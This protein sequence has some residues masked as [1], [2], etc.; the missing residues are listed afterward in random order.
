MRR[1]QPLPTPPRAEPARG[2]VVAAQTT[3]RSKR[4]P[5]P[6]DQD[7]LATD[8]D[9]Q[10]IDAWAETGQTPEPPA[11]VV[12]PETPSAEPPEDDAAQAQTRVGLL[13]VWK[14]SRASRK[15]LRREVRRFTGRARR[16]R[17]VWIVSISSVLLLIAGS[18]AVAYS[19]LFAVQKIT[20][21]GAAS[22]DAD[23][24]V[25][26]LDGQRGVPLAAVDESAIKSA[27]VTFPLIE[28]YAIEAHPPHEL[29]IRIVERQPIGVVRSDAGYTLVDAAGVALATTQE[30]PAGQPLLEAA[31]GTGSK[32]FVAM[33]L[34]IRSLPPEIRA[35]VTEVSATSPNSVQLR[36]GSFNVDVI[37]GSAADSVEKS[38]VLQA[39]MQTNPP[40]GV[41]EYDVSTPDAIVIR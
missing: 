32:S 14:A 31:G 22:M 11:S 8:V 19:P 12:E 21:A 10:T 26:A 3:K 23:A 7:A 1:P 2:E 27:L 20:V 18:F 24:I 29:V 39:A 4:T 34:V 6:V 33:G 38:L 40:A 36:L 30:A 13:D 41:S 25:A 28:T 5:D 9:V 37:W 35:L 15:V 17:L 16:R